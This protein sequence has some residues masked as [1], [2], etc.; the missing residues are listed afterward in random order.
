MNRACRGLVLLPIAMALGW[1]SGCGGSGAGLVP[2]SGTIK[3]D[4]QPLGQ[5]QILFVPIAATTADAELA[6]V[7][8]AGVTDAQGK[9]QLLTLDHGPGAVPGK[10]KVEVTMPKGAGGADPKAAQYENVLEDMSTKAQA[11]LDRIP[12][13]YN[14]NS[15][16]TFDVPAE[17]TDQA[18]FDLL[19][20]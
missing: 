19:T 12:A 7:Q 14:R 20:K 1:M 10:H 18:N 2:V 15:E 3:L 4:G 17:G 16:L 6:S 8:S 13:R 11:A 9:Y 5:A